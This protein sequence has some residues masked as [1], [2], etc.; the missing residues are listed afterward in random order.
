MEMEMAREEAELA[1]AGQQALEEERRAM[2]QGAGLAADP[3]PLAQEPGMSGGEF[4]GDTSAAE[5]AQQA[6]LD[7]SA[8]LPGV[9]A[10]GAGAATAEG[11]GGEGASVMPAPPGLGALRYAVE[12]LDPSWRQ[13]LQEE[14]ESAYFA[15]IARYL[16]AEVKLMGF[17]VY[18][19]P[20]LIFNAFDSTPFDKVKVVILGQDPYHGEGQ[21][22]GLAFS[23][24]PGVRAPPSLQNIFKELQDDPA[25]DFKA[26]P[27]KGGD[28]SPWARQG[29]LLLNTVLTVRGGEAL[30][31]REFGWDRLTDAAI[32]RLNEGRRDLVFVLWGA[33]A[34]KKAPL[35]TGETHAVLMSSHPS[36]LSAQKGRNPFS[37]CRHFSLVNH[38]LR[39]KGIPEIDWNSL[40]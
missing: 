1:R 34:Q 37:G 16:R 25:V 39:E 28:L 5:A 20:D 10:S 38:V 19:T 7:V 29:V 11:A 35:I 18:P 36:P 14:F 2:S 21:A 12:R 6:P 4:V 24:P 9:E 23:V 8:A 17:Q 30:S 31:H 15:D 33:N 3:A 26:P 13:V 22:H 32:M 27:N 40:S